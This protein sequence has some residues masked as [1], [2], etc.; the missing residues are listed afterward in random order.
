MMMF[1][2]P[3]AL[4]EVKHFKCIKNIYKCQ[5]FFATR[6]NQAGKAGYKKLLHKQ[7]SQVFLSNIHIF[8][9]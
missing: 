5:A 8:N 6:R 3:T 9:A 2:N 4:S 7:F 1:N